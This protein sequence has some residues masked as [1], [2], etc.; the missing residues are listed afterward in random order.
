[1]TRQPGQP[2]QVKIGSDVWIGTGAVVIS[3]VAPGT[4]VG[5]GAVV[6]KAFEPYSI[7]GGVPAKVIGQ[8][9]PGPADGE[10]SQQDK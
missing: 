6:T 3:D 1:M 8:R 10:L 5:A 2:K 9:Q 7:L 4:I